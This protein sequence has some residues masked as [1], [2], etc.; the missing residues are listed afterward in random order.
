[1]SV[2]LFKG[3]LRPRNEVEQVFEAYR[4][5]MPDASDAYV[6]GQIMTDAMFRRGS[7]RAAELHA[8][9]S[10][11]HTYL[12]Q[13]N[14]SSPAC[15][16]GI[17]AMHGL[18]VPFVNQNLEAFA[19]ILG[20]LESLRGMADTIS[21]AWVNFAREGTPHASGMPA[22]AP[23]DTDKRPTMIF[24]TEIELRHDVDRHLRDIW[25]G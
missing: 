18:D 25:S 22:W 17:G 9:A 8:V 14:W 10:P 6:R 3:L 16:G 23:F 7:V 15:D 1:M 4:Q 12:Y 19:P 21:D 5:A 24:D 13:F 20:D 11:G 2:G